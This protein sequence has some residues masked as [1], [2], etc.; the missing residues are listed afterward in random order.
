MTRDGLPSKDGTTF[1][2][3]GASMPAET[4]LVVNDRAG[5]ADHF[6]RQFPNWEVAVSADYLSAIADLS[7]KPATTVVACVDASQLDLEKAVAGLR[8]A[9]GDDARLLLCCRAEAEM[10]TMRGVAAGADDYLLFPLKDEEIEAAFADVDGSSSQA[11]VVSVAELK[12]LGEVVSRIS[13]APED[14]LMPLAELL[15]TAM[16]AVSGRVV[17]ESTVAP[18]GEE[19]D[20]PEMLEAV[21][22]AEQ[23]IGHVAVGPRAKGDYGPHDVTRFQQYAK[24]IGYIVGAGREQQRL[25]RL[26]Y[27]D[28]LSGLPNRRYLFE[29]MGRM[30]RRAEEEGSTLTLLMFD[31]DNFKSYNDA[32]GHDAGDEIIRGCGE[33]FRANVRDHDVVTRYGGDEF[34]VIFWDKGKRRVEGSCHPT[35]VLP[36][37]ERFRRSLRT[38][39]FERFKL[40][41]NARLTISGGLAS[42]PTDAQTAEALI[43]AADE[44]LLLAKREGKNCIYLSG[45]NGGRALGE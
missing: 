2:F 13:G 39:K 12:A 45:E 4:V 21:Y 33:L 37:I 44:A 25:Q 41:D 24:L 35:N 14:L 40:A 6:R 38:H 19:L 20:D 17:I 9:A 30:I 8:E 27:T 32:F 11:A 3:S 1:S 28:E 22:H 42:F 29:F 31:I 5:V 15:R 43:T 7:R 36:L 23:S 18:S 16:G 26:A 34:A 10:M